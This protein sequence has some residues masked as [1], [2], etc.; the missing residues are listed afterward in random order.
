MIACDL[1][2]NTLR[3]VKIDPL[4]KERLKEYEKSVRTAKNL[5]KTGEI[6][7]DSIQRI[8]YALKE[9][10]IL[11]DFK[12]NEVH[13][14]TTEAMRKANNSQEILKQIKNEFGLD[15]KIIDGQEEARLTLL[16]V[17]HAIKKCK[18]ITNSYCVIDLGGGSTEISFINDKDIQ[19]KSFGFGIV[20]IAEKYESSIKKIENNIDEEVKIIDSF[21]KDKKCTH[22]IATAGTPTTVCAFLEGIDYKNYDY[23][24]IN[25]KSLH[26]EDFS[27]ALS[28]LLR[29]DKKSREFWV[30]TNRSDLVCA[31]ILIVIAIMK[32][33]KFENCIVID[34]SLREGL[35]ISKCKINVI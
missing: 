9:A 29:M 3:I 31:G 24:K 26:V 16:G 17:K 15:F 18:I 25:G 27:K 20:K 1:G 5:Y 8:F 6:S 32:K 13:C 10:D 34:D 35:A 2:S 33:L 14:V 19:S 11:F 28:K 22:L 7:Q 21:I 12:N 4:S 30:G 23:K